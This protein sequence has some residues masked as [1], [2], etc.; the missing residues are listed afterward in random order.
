MSNSTDPPPEYTSINCLKKINNDDNNKMKKMNIPTNSRK[1][2][3][4]L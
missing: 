3:E 2:F 4:A 1:D